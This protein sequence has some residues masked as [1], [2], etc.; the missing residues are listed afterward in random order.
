MMADRVWWMPP[1]GALHGVPVDSLMWWNL[2]IL[3]T[4]FL[5]AHVFVLAT[6][7]RRKGPVLNRFG[8]SP[9]HELV[10][11]I[12]L[13]L[14]YAW[15]AVSA[16]RLWA[17][18]RYQ[19][20]APNA[21]QVEVTGMQFQWYFRYPGADNSFGPTRP[22]LINAP[23]GNPLGL[24]H[25]DPH[26]ADDIVSS[27]LLLPAGREV[28]LR[29]RSIDVIHGFFVPGMR[30]KQ[31][32]VPGME[33]HIHFTPTVAGDYPILCSQVC[34]LGHARMQSHL[35]VVS[36]SEYSAWLSSHSPTGISGA[37]R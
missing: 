23:A 22:E 3:G 28:D 36:E 37:G 35:R 9:K 2:V 7:I 30:V 6:M 25:T 14:I 17:T 20:A 29:I 4:L 15:M 18:I 1:N 24:D 16:Q 5:L 21:L 31:N 27:V 10:P 33:M 8:V 19:G 26:S 11:L 12:A 32:A 13:T 34:G